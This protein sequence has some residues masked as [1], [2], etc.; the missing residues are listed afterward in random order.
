MLSA[1]FLTGTNRYLTTKA[2]PASPVL[3]TRLRRRRRSCGTM[4][5]TRNRFHQ[6][7]MLFKRKAAAILVIPSEKNGSCTGL[8]GKYSK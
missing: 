8:A 3:D 1:R 5:V 2:L 7:R 4:K 6:L